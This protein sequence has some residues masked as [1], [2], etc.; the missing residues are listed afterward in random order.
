[1]FNINKYF[2][3]YPGTP[4]LGV[5]NDYRCSVHYGNKYRLL[6]AEKQYKKP[7]VEIAKIIEYTL[8]FLNEIGIQIEERKK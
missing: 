5:K 7:A 6:E 4:P 8:G 3:I 1:M 2:D